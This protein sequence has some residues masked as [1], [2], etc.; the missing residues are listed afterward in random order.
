MSKYDK[1]SILRLCYCKRH[2]IILVIV[3]WNVLHKTWNL[4][5]LT[6]T[7]FLNFFQSLTIVDTKVITWDLFRIV[8]WKQRFIFD[9]KFKI[10][11]FCTTYRSLTIKVIYLSFLH[12]SPLSCL[13]AERVKDEYQL[14]ISTIFI[15]FY[16]SVH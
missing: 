10:K 6:C 8:F 11:S 2:E 16:W 1:R 5:Q 15:I 3:T 9:L 13:W 12:P 4:Y 14:S 7:E